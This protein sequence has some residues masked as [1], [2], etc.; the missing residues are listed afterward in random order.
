M[1][2]SAAS[3]S[4]VASFPLAQIVASSRVHDAHIAALGCGRA[5]ARRA[6]RRGDGVGMVVHNDAPALLATVEQVVGDAAHQRPV[7]R[8]HI[9]LWL[10]RVGR[11]TK[12][13][14]WMPPAC[15]AR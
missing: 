4:R 2:G 6:R 9:A 5:E 15:I 8:A 11:L 12:Q 3:S 7:V 13:R 14:M 1:L 10:E